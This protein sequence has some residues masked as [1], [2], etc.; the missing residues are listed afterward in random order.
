MHNAYFEGISLESL[1][2]GFSSLALGY[3]SSMLLQWFTSKFNF[4]NGWK[5]TKFTKLKTRENL[6][7]TVK[8]FVLKEDILTFLYFIWYFDSVG[9]CGTLTNPTNGQVNHTAGTTEGRT[10]TYSCNTGYN[11][12]GDIT[13]MCQATGLWS[14]S[15]PTCRRMFQKLVLRN[16][17]TFHHAKKTWFLLFNS[18]G[19]WH[20]G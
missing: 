2:C 19:L 3:C 11:L 15:E 8:M 9:E 18:C 16:K 20:S 1:S 12:V 7:Y 13:R 14:R 17:C 10:A 6:R 5:L 4:A